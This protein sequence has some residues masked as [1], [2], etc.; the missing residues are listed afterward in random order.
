MA[1]EFKGPDGQTYDLSHVKFTRSQ[2]RLK[3]EN[4][5]Y[6]APVLLSFSHHCYTDTQNA[7]GSL[8]KPG[9]PWFYGT[10]D[11]G[12]HRVFCPT[13]Y[14]AS[15]AL[16]AYLQTLMTRGLD[17]F[18]LKKA[19]N[20]FRIHD[21]TVNSNVPNSKDIGW[22]IFF[23]FSRASPGLSLV[24]IDVTVTTREKNSQILRDLD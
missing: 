23:S 2:V 10:D 21:N 13:R 7:D 5:L 14:A 3:I 24:K 22:Y 18:Q 17:C 1:H 9:D 19:N 12:D 4:L 16:P 11:N 8:A 15:L 20:F 6:D